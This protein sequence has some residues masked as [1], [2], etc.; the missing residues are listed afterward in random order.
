MWLHWEL[1]LTFRRLSLAH[2][3]RKPPPP[4]KYLA[5]S[6]GLHLLLASWSA[7]PDRPLPVRLALSYMSR[8]N[9]STGGFGAPG[10][11]HLPSE[12]FA[13][14]NV[15]GETSGRAA[16][17]FFQPPARLA[18]THLAC[19]FKANTCLASTKLDFILFIWQFVSRTAPRQLT[20]LPPQHLTESN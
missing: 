13:L 16:T 20:L 2:P 6:Q 3:L 7:T 9:N 1:W 19:F 11:F 17:K 5:E 4:A 12:N 15:F 18:R 8:T 14:E 10:N